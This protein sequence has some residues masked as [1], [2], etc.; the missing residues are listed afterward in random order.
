MADSPCTLQ[1]F[2][3][4]ARSE[5]V[6]VLMVAL[7]LW[8]VTGASAGVTAVYSN[9]FHD[10]YPR[11]GQ[12]FDLSPY[13]LEAPAVVWSEAHDRKI[14]ILRTR[15]DKYGY[16]QQKCVMTIEGSGLTNPRFLSVLSFRNVEASW[17]TSKLILIKLDIGHAA[18]VEAIYDAEGD[19]LIYCESVSYYIESG[20]GR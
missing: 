10:H 9:D 4:S 6:A 8:Q 20:K 17:I 12:R 16:E 1:S 11:V 2:D 5:C 7:C 13:E 19:R 14:T 3:M 18:G 15:G